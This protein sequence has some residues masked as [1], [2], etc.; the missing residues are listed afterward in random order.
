AA[1]RDPAD[2]AAKTGRVEAHVAHDVAG[3]PALVPHGLDGH[4]VVDLGVAL[5]VAGDADPAERGARCG[6]PRPPRAASFSASPTVGSRPLTG[7]AVIAT[8]IPAGIQSATACSV[9]L[10]GITSDRGDRESV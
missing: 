6:P 8:V 4:V 1:R 5:R 7:D 9:P 2:Q 10:A 3:V